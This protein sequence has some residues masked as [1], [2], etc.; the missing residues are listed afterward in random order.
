MRTNKNVNLSFK[1]MNHY[2]LLNAYMTNK[3][4]KDLVLKMFSIIFSAIN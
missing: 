4:I 2:L 3:I 1:M